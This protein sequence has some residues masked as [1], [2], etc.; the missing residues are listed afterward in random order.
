MKQECEITS[1]RLSAARSKK[2]QVRAAYR[3]TN[4]ILTECLSL[5]PRQLN[6]NCLLTAT[7]ARN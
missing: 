4:F 3:H 6:S 1:Q 5:P 7:A 2:F